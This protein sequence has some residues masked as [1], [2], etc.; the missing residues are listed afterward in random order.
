MVCVVY[1]TGLSPEL[2]FSLLQAANF[3][4]VRGG[5]T[6]CAVLSSGSLSRIKH[7]YSRRANIWGC[8]RLHLTLSVF[9]CRIPAF[10]W[11]RALKLLS[12]W[13]DQQGFKHFH[14]HNVM[15]TRGGGEKK[16]GDIN[17]QQAWN[18]LYISTLGSALSVS[19]NIINSLWCLSHCL[20]T[21]LW[22]QFCEGN[23]VLQKT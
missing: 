1:F 22:P 6:Q 2:T 16:Q 10:W 20:L 11:S 17:S 21:N 9:A 13:K 14:S 8:T 23:L 4:Q 5:N 15:D 7:F 19:F 3:G 12:P 18:H